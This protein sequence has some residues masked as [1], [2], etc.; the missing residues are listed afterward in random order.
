MYSRQESIY[1]SNVVVEIKGKRANSCVLRPKNPKAVIEASKDAHIATC[2]DCFIKRRVFPEIECTGI[3]GGEA[4]VVNE[5]SSIM[6]KEEW[7]EE[8]K[9]KGALCHSYLS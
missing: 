3:V 1:A 4:A 9:L 2:E 8:L 6:N 5:L 7:K